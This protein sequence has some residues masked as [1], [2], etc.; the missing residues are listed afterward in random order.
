MLEKDVQEIEPCV[1]LAQNLDIPIFYFDFDK[2]IVRY[3][4]EI[5]L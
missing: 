4:S 5:E 2:F 1:D 3:D